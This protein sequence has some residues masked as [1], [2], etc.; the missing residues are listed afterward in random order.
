MNIN[1]IELL[2]LQTL[3]MQQDP[4]TQAMCNALNPQFKTIS[5]NIGKCLILSNVN[6]LSAE[7]LDELAYELH[8]D[9]YDSAASIDIKRALIKN[10]D[11]VHMYLG[12][13]FAIEQ[14]VLDYFGDGY[15]EEWYKYAGEPY[16]FRVVTSNTSV[17]GELA[18]LFASTIEKVK[19]KSTI[20]DAVI[21]DLSAEM[22]TYFACALHIGDYYITE[23][24]V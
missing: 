5:D 9:W 20:M 19:R 7:L 15:V 16:H 6:N 4:T 12:T 22:N 2:K 10:S 21:V 23:Q 14:V 18:D 1:N 24:V 8:V 17:S 3:F 11:K 13:P